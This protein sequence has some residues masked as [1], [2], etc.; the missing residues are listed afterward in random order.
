MSRFRE[1]G[2]RSPVPGSDEPDQD[3]E[4]RGGLQSYM[5][6][7]HLGIQFAVTIALLTGGGVWL[8]RKLGTTPLFILIGLFL[9]FGGGFYHLYRAIYTPKP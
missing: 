2:G 9:G 7:S 1:L 6:Y 8:D 5:Q 3:H 4:P